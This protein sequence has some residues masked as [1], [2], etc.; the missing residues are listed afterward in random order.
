MAKVL[1]R[2]E[3]VLWKFLF[4]LLYL[5]FNRRASDYCIYKLHTTDST[6]CFTDGTTI[7]EINSKIEEISNAGWLVCMQAIARFSTCTQ[8]SHTHRTRTHHSHMHSTR[9]QHWHTA[10]LHSI[11]SLFVNM[12]RTQLLRRLKFL[13]FTIESPFL[14]FLPSVSQTDRALMI[15]WQQPVSW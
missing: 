1:W 6:V 7:E 5:H 9:E 2:N 3:I 4:A 12:Q 13:L 14:C 11:G 10:L 15:Q 8:H